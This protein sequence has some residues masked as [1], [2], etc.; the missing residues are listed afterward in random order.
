MDGY[1]VEQP[2]KQLSKQLNYQALRGL[3]GDCILCMFILHLQYA[4]LTNLIV[5]ISSHK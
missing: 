1:N 5:L 2:Q 4:S 3:I